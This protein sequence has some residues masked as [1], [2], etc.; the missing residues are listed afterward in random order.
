M[1]RAPIP[2]DFKDMLVQVIP[3]VVREK[4]WALW[5]LGVVL[6]TKD[7]ILPCT[8]DH[9]SVLLFTKA[10]SMGHAPAQCKLGQMFFEGK[11]VKQ[12]KKKA[13]ELFTRSAEQGFA[14]ACSSLGFIFYTGNG[15]KKDTA[16]ALDFWLRASRHGFKPAMKAIMKYIIT[17]SLASFVDEPNTNTIERLTK[18]VEQGDV[19]AQYRLGVI[20]F[21]PIG[22]ER[23]V[24][25]SAE[26]WGKASEQGHAGAHQ[27]LGDMFYL[28]I[29]VKKD[30]KKA[31]ELYEKATILGQVWA[32]WKCAWIK[33]IKLQESTEK[34]EINRVPGDQKA[35][36]ACVAVKPTRECFFAFI[37]EM[38]DA[39]VSSAIAKG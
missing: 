3:H 19:L 29:G 17:T 27:K 25:K 35:D 34:I 28:G 36:Q 38:R 24:T 18:R 37:D 14:G 22:V 7:D 6:C 20:Y 15:V 13:M 1:C 30:V 8:D 23:D 16:K 21:I 4:P 31:E 9:Y 2:S 26:L 32:R 11:G 5:S 39:L 10:A 12:D 33:W